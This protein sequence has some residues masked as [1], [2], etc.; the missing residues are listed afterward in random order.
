MKPKDRIFF[1]VTGFGASAQGF[2][3]RRNGSRPELKEPHPGAS[4]LFGL[5][6]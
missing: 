1:L 2:E 6:V 5:I 3:F 4:R